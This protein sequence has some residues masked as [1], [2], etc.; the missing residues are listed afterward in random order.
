MITTVNPEQESVIRRIQKLLALGQSPN[1]AEANLAM[2]RA[3][4]LLAKHNLEAAMVKDAVVA[5]GTVQVEEKRE[6]TRISRS[7]QYK[8]QQSL[9]KAIAEA[10][11]CWYSIIEVFE[12]KRGV[13]RKSKVP[14]KRHLVI[15]TESNVMAV[16]MMGE[17]LEDTLE[18]LVVTDA[19]Y[20]NQ[21]RMSRAAIS[22]KTGCADRL[23][24]RIRQQ[25]EGRKAKSD[26][27]RP[28]GAAGGTALVL[29]D[30]YQREYAANYDVRYGAGAYA[31]KLLSDAEWEAGREAREAQ[32]Q[33]EREQAE[34][35]WIEYLKTETPAQ[36]KA[37]EREETRQ[38]IRDEKAWARRV[39][40][41]H[42]QRD[43]EASKID[44][45]AY[46]AGKRAGDGISLN[47]QVV[48]SKPRKDRALN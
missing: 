44:G 33:A 19:G 43:R 36:K 46:R 15:G 28:E 24:E 32:A 18:R 12:G 6:K 13:G 2:A 20:T 5:G 31:R 10:N 25:A 17:Y 16:R 7:A 38:R 26:A 48:E 21:S 14:V 47:A 42:N 35:D 23:E 11:F 9:W 4:E 3:Q 39:N 29:R 1:E 22:W 8:W 34:R 30:V 27:A 41:Y 37:R 40:S 45:E